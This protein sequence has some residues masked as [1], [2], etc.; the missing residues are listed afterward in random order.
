MVPC[1]KSLLNRTLFLSSTLSF[2]AFILSVC[3]GTTHAQHSQLPFAHH[4][5]ASPAVYQ[6]APSDSTRTLTFLGGANFLNSIESEGIAADPALGIP[7]I[8]AFN[9]DADTGY[10]ISFAFGR[11]HSHTLRSEIE[12][13]IRENDIELQGQAF[14]V[15]GSVLTFD[16]DE[17]SAYSIMKNFI[18]DFENSSVFTPYV[19]VG[20]GL[21]YIDLEFGEATRADGEATFQDG[22]GAF[23][24]QAIGGVA[25]KL[26]SFSD[27]IVEYRFLGTSEIEF[28]GLTDTF[29]FNTSTLFMGL[30]FEY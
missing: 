12:L 21:S 10:A 17:I 3:V 9:T 11:R 18:R 27:F 26:N 16:E 8:P 28:D 19:G 25:T 29:A 5:P 20:I 22:A 14:P 30:A 2:S 15:G 1:P 6:N 7:T 4:L 24:Y 13:A 23:T